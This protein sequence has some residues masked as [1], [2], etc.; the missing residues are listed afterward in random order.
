MRCPACRSERT[1]PALEAS[2]VQWHRCRSC[3]TLF[4]AD[5]PGDAVL[6]DEYRG[7]EYFAKAEPEAG[8]E[9][10]WGYPDDYLEDR[11]NVEAKFERILERIETLVPPGRLLDV[12]CGPG[13]LLGVA[14]RRGWEPVGVD[15][16]EWAVA[17]ARDELGRDA[18]HGTLDDQGFADGEFDAVTMLDLIEHVADPAGLVE[19]AARITRAGGAIAVLTPDAGGRVP[20]LLGQRWPELRRP[21]EHLVLLSAEG[22]AKLLDRAGFNP[23]GR[24]SI[25]KEAPLE[26]LIADAAPLAPG[27][28]RI[29][30]RSVAGNR[31]G[32]RIVNLDPRT[33]LVMYARRRPRAE[34]PAGHLA[35][36]VSRRASGEATTETAILE[37]LRHLGQAERL[38]DWMFEQFAGAVGPRV[39]EVGA[40]I[41]T[42]TQRLLE[43]GAQEVLAVE[44]EPSCADEL[45]R[46][47]GDDDRVRIA[48]EEIPESP[49][50]AS[51]EARADLVLC[52]NV[53]EHIADD[54][55]A[56]TAM[57]GALRPGGVLALLVPAGPRLF[58]PLDAAYGHW[59]R[60][61]RREVEEVIA[62]AGLE[63]ESIR[64][65]NALGIA[66]WW[67]KNRRPGAR[68]G[69]GSLRAYEALV[70][71]WRPI[72]DRVRPPAGLSLVALARRP[73]EGAVRLPR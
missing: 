36:R 51:W 24:H 8:A 48:R 10:L 16:N 66:G 45:E 57:A 12:G 22:L 3:R 70:R 50:L 62:I 6:A 54:G 68:V 30:L 20:R 15:L 52:Q 38:G 35:P 29:A 2:G 40:G 60:Y 17:H 63:L 13:F 43:A 19:E 9:T 58:G 49:A 42:F 14:K 59:R 23:A 69:P 18:R 64:H 21:R 73:P 44:P 5:P 33:K 72:E 31:V 26:T 53:L 25:G 47:F 1:R 37:E 7:R 32:R 34:R 71:F 46:R 67:A 65:F 55:G 11:P 4:D 28:S 61:T 41:G 39:V 27:L 56:V